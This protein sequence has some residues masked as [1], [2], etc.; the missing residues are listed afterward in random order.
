MALQR[1]IWSSLLHNTRFGCSIQFNLH[2][3]DNTLSYLSGQLARS[4][5]KDAISPPT[6]KQ[7]I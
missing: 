6:P 5:Y 7:H 2:T 4:D 3:S 1:M